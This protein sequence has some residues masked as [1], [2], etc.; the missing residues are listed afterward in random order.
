MTDSLLERF[1]NRYGRLPT[2]VDP[3]YLEMLNMSKYRRLAVP[4]FAPGKCANCGSSRTNDREYL[5]FGLQVDW[6]GTVYLCSLCIADMAKTLGLYAAM[7]DER[8]KLK[9]GIND[10]ADRHRGLLI[11]HD[12]LKKDYQKLLAEKSVDG[13][14]SLL[15]DIKEQNDQ[16]LASGQSNSKSA[17][18]NRTGS[19]S[20]KATESKSISTE[21]ESG[22]TQQADEPGRKNIR[23]LDE[24]LKDGNTN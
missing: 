18:S 3:D 24:L 1:V 23:S 22:I 2:E 5:D 15:L 12:N 9:L 17:P 6:Y 19:R 8:E 21:S 11:E 13:L 10:F 7:E 20:A 16:L 4:D 14:R